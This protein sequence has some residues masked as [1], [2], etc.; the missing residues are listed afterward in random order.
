MNMDRAPSAQWKGRVILAAWTLYAGYY[1]CRKDMG[2]AKGGAISS[3]ALSL[4]CFGGMYAVGQLVG[5]TLA[6]RIG[7]RRTALAGAGIRYFA[8]YHSFGAVNRPWR[9][10]SSWAMD[11]A[12]ASDGLPCSNCSEAGFR[13]VNEIVCSVG[14]ALA[15]SLADYSRALLRPGSFSIPMWPLGPAFTQ[16]ILSL[17]RCCC[18]RHF[19]SKRL[20]DCLPRPRWRRH[21]SPRKDQY[22]ITR[23]TNYS[24]TRESGSSPAYIS[25]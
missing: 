5:G 6:D 23:G 25:F 11:S 12:K 20:I 4:A 16:P 10:C 15:I 21:Q 1:M 22:K 9:S 18:V 14:G 8:R 13:L 2:T 17:P 19:F 24:R 7:A 3:L